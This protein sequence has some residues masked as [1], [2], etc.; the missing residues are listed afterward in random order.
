LRDRDSCYGEVFSKRIEAMGIT[1]VM[2]AARSP[3]QNPYV[4]RVIGSIRRECLNHFI[5]FNDAICVVLA[6][7]RDYY[8]RTVR[9]CRF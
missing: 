2:T 3:S 5:I 8:H 9:I 4:E 7:Y 6:S 1:E